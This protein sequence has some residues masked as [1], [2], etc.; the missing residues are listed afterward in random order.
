MN[1]NNNNTKYV[2]YLMDTEKWT[3]K[4]GNDTYAE[5]AIGGPTI[6]LYLAS[7]NSFDIDKMY[8]GNT[9]GYGYY[10][11]GSEAEKDTT[12]QVSEYKNQLY[13]PGTSNSQDYNGYWLASPSASGSNNVLYVGCLNAKNCNNDNY[14]GFRP[15]VCLK[16]NYKLEQVGN[17]EAYNIVAK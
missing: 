7:W 16:S 6:E 11:G 8:C 12:R 15:V 5:F 10:I 17:E 3:E 2:G 14:Y 9:N 13:Y 4:Y 1:S